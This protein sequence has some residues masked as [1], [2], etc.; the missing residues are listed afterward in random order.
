MDI[1]TKVD[2]LKD[3]GEKVT[4][5]TLVPEENETVVGMIDKIAEHYEGGGGGGTTVV[6]NPQLSGT[7]AELTSLQVG[8]TKY[9]NP[10]G[11]TVT[12]GT[13][14]LTAGTSDLATGTF[15][16]VYE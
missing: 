1:R 13:T 8:E 4:G 15:Y 6:A 16:F 12:Y 9:K 11:A 2:A 5:A 14:D 3:L 10:V 7:E